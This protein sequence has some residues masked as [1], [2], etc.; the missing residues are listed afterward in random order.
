MKTIIGFMAVLALTALPAF[1]I[2]GSA[3]VAGHVLDPD[4]IPV[5]NV[6]VAIFRL[7]L[8]QVDSAVATVKTDAKGYFVKLPLQ[9]GRYMLD[10]AVPG[11]TSA[12][13]VH[14]LVDETVTNVTLRLHANAGCMPVH[15]HASMVNGDLTSD[16]W[17]IH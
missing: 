7:P 1:A 8:H 4:G 3:G 11:T 6:Q 12:C 10:V 17:I 13:G 16:V 9:P 5:A 2:T 14:E 15:I